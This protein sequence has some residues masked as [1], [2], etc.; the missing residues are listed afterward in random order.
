LGFV[1]FEDFYYVFLGFVVF[2]DFYYVFLGFV[3]FE[4]FYYDVFLYEVDFEKTFFYL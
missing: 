3:V 4:D 1:V 2:E